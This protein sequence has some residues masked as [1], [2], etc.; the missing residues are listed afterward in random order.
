MNPHAHQYPEHHKHGERHEVTMS[1]RAR[2][3]LA[4]QMCERSLY[5]QQGAE[6]TVQLTEVP[7]QAPAPDMAEQAAPVAP[8]VERMVQNETSGVDAIRAQ[9]M[10]AFTPKQG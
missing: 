1:R 6:V 3:M 4:Q 10:A 9:I 2:R 7:V 5:H 8:G